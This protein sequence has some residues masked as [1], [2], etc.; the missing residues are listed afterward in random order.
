MHRFSFICFLLA[1][2]FLV[3]AYKHQQSFGQGHNVAVSSANIDTIAEKATGQKVG[4]G[5][6]GE[7]IDLQETK[8]TVSSKVKSLHLSS[9]LSCLYHSSRIIHNITHGHAK[10]PFNIYHVVRAAST[11][12]PGPA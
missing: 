1:A 12:H 9:K 4:V 5:A 8:T 11:C 2:V 6:V 3:S 10:S 7:Q